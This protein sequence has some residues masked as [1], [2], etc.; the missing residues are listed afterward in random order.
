MKNVSFYYVISNNLHDP[1]YV[2]KVKGFRQMPDKQVCGMGHLV[3][4]EVKVTS[5]IVVFLLCFK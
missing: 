3:A 2:R 5:S 1:G 4:F